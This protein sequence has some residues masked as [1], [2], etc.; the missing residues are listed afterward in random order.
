MYLK[1]KTMVLC[2]LWKRVLVRFSL[3]LNSCQGS[4]PPH[5]LYYMGMS[6]EYLFRHPFFRWS[7]KAIKATKWLYQRMLQLK[8]RRHLITCHCAYM[9]LL[10]L[11]PETKNIAA[12][13]VS[14]KWHTSNRFLSIISDLT[15]IVGNW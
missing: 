13:F 8:T 1:V 14:Y 7:G 9:K 11:N 10:V 3:Q 5:R 12:H 6:L 4:S 2:H 15:F